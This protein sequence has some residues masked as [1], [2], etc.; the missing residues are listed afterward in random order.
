MMQLA[1][2]GALK[3]DSVRHFILDEC[4]KMLD[5]MGMHPSATDHAVVLC[6]PCAAFGCGSMLLLRTTCWAVCYPN[7]CAVRT[8]SQALIV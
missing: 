2:E 1:K 3:M 7:A 6:F 5:K 8:V 4:D